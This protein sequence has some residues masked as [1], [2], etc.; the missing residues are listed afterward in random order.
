MSSSYISVALVTKSPD[1]SEVCSPDI[2]HSGKPTE[3]PRSYA[4]NLSLQNI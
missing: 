1:K 3:G 2:Q 4:H